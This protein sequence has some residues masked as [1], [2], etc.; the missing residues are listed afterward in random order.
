MRKVAIVSL[1]HNGTRHRS[2]D[3]AW[4]AG[5]RPLRLFIPAGTPV[6][7]SDGLAWSSGYDVEAHFHPKEWYN[8]F[9]LKKSGGRE[10]YCNVA[11]PPLFDPE[12][13]EVRFVDYDL[14]VY[15]Y[16]DGSF[17]VLD[18][19]EFEENARKMGYS[20]EI[21]E[22]AEAGLKK[23]IEAVRGKREPFV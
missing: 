9:V 10:W 11:S 8:V 2:W 13:A 16:A 23:L 6:R 5:E 19:E 20:M 7:N 1:K 17:K 14:D 12:K 3:G 18:R 15:V 21:R 4:L 22:K